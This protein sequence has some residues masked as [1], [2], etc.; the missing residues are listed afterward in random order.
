MLDLST[1]LQQM[2]RFRNLLVHVYWEIDYGR[3]FDVIEHDLDDLRRFSR[4][5]AALV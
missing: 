1:R 3:V 5:V 2:A 4:T